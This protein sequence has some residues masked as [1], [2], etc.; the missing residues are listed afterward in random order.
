M[1]LW[2][3]DDVSMKIVAVFCGGFFG[4]CGLLSLRKLLD[5][6]PGLLIDSE[7]FTDN[8]SAMGAGRVEW[9]DVT[10]LR[11]S[12]IS[13]QTFLTV[14]VANPEACIERFGP[15]AAQAARMNLSIVGSPVNISANSLSTDLDEL[16]A[17]F[18]RFYEHH[19]R[20]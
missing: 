13:G 11:L 12:T 8:S 2:G 18:K 3:Q 16:Y 9:K 20:A 17:T 1:W 5:P 7:G 4:F 10:G 19:R 14:D 6:S 15:L